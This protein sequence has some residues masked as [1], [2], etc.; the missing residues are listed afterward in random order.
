MRKTPAVAFVVA[1][2]GSSFWAAAGIAHE[3]N[4]VG[5]S[6]N[7]TLDGHEHQDHMWGEGGDDDLSGH[8]GADEIYGGNQNDVAKGMQGQDN[9]KT[10][11]DYNG[12]DTARGGDDYDACWVNPADSRDN[13]EDVIILS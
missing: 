8:G 13:C 3:T 10:Y 5:G 12:G 4:I 2:V 9:P 6:G 1:L 11:D 7:N